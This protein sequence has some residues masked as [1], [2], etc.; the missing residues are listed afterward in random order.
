MRKAGEKQEKSR[1]K[2]GEKQE[3]SRRKAGEIYS[4]KKAGSALLRPG[5]YCYLKLSIW[6]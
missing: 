5:L 2:A 6:S 4:H 1:R 3:K